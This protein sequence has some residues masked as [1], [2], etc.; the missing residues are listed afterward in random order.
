MVVMK[1]CSPHPTGQ[2]PRA[3]D[4][5]SSAVSLSEQWACNEIAGSVDLRQYLQLIYCHDRWGLNS[6]TSSHFPPL[7]LLS[8]FTSHIL[9]GSRGSVYFMMIMRTLLTIEPRCRLWL[10]PLTCRTLYFLPGVHNHF[11]YLFFLIIKDSVA[12]CLIISSLNTFFFFN[13]HHLLSI[14]STQPK[15]VG[16]IFF[17]F[18]G[19]LHS[20]ALPPPVPI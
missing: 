11:G 5:S 8:A 10:C 6:H 19:K 4:V 16:S 2:V 17:F 18:S 15:L 7:I 20:G 12:Q 3:S 1:S 14:F 13:A 9:I